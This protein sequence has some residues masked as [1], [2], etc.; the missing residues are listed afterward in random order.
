MALSEMDQ[1]V[2]HAST[3]NPKCQKWKKIE[4]GATVV[5]FLFCADN[6]NKFNFCQVYRRKRRALSDGNPAKGSSCRVG[7]V[8]GPYYG[9]LIL[10]CF[11]EGMGIREM[12]T[13]NCRVKWCYDQ[14]SKQLSKHLLKL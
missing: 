3:E 1:G 12:L 10:F 13:A 7:F 9:R 2:A 14:S 11:A 5:G 6:E 4:V 8:E